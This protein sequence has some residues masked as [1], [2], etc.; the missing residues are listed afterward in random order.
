[1]GEHE[2]EGSLVIRL[3]RSLHK[4]PPDIRVRL[5]DADKR[6]DNDG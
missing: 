6:G 3:F 1:M 4:N 5:L 2:E